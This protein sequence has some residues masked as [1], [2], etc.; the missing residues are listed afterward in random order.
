VLNYKNIFLIEIFMNDQFAIGFLAVIPLRSQAAHASEMVSQLIFGETMQI[1]EKN[2]DWLKVLILYDDYEGWVEE[3]QIQY[4]NA[5]DINNDNSTYVNKN[6]LAKVLK[7][8][9]NE[10]VFI[11]SGASLPFYKDGK[12]TIGEF[13]YQ[14]E[15]SDNESSNSLNFKDD[16][17]T[18]AKEFLNTP[19][20][21]G[22]RTFMGIDCSGFSQIV[23]KMFGIKIKRD[24]SQQA[25][26]GKLVDFLE[27]AQAGDLAFFDNVEGKITHV[28]IMINNHQIIHASGRVKIDAI[29]NEGI[30][31]DDLKKYTHKLRIIK[32]Y[33]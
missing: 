29:D 1:L 11:T 24:A 32:R 17:I 28:G 30:F 6:N 16:V 14:L 19:Y 7:E 3:K 23:F 13:I 18:K 5:S 33:V 31:S 22:G 2:G 25:T 9:N 27:E 21:W 20:L 12:F 4:L 15:N 8:L 10:R 26:Q